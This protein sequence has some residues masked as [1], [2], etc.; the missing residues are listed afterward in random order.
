MRC[1]T[2]LVTITQFCTAQN[3][4]DDTISQT[5]FAEI[6]SIWESEDGRYLNTYFNLHV[7]KAKKEQ[8]TLELA[9]AYRYIAWSLPMKEGIKSVDSAISIISGMKRLDKVDLDE[10][11]TLAYYTK[12]AQFYENY[13]DEQ[14]TEAFI[15]S[16]HLAKKSNHKDLMIIV[17]SELANVKAEFGQESEAIS[18]Q[19]KTLA[20]LEKNKTK[21][22]DYQSLHLDNLHTMVRCYTY[23]KK[24]DSARL[25]LKEAI[26]IATENKD[27]DELQDLREISAEVDYYDNDILRAKDTL[28]K[29]IKNTNGTSKANKLFYLGQ[30][31]GRLGYLDL[32]K[33]YFQSFDSIMGTI[34]Y[35]LLDNANEVY[36]FLLKDA[37][38][39]NSHAEKRYFNRLVYYDSLLARTQERLRE[40]TLKKFDL[41]LQQEEESLMNNIISS[42]S[43][44]I[45]VFYFICGALIVGLLGYY[46][47]YRNTKKR[48]ELALKQP[49][50]LETGNFSKSFKEPTIDID[51]GILQEILKNLD[52]WEKEK[53]FLDNTVNQQSLAKTLNTNSSYLSQ[54]INVNK[55]HNFSSYL[56]DLRITYAINNLKSS[57]NVVKGKSMIQIAELYGFS[58]LAVF[59]KAFKA[60]VGVT[61]GVFLKQLEKESFAQLD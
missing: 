59:N 38:D 9:R 25:Y 39:N 45:Q 35:P 34:N 17:L 13:Y 28:S 6:R 20:F 48:L 49:V 55:G 43:K 10:F 1:F 42:K 36:R 44:R 24:V 19:K 31:E 4:T 51:A 15:K 14:A 26:K 7:A 50:E 58:S 11:M 21:V 3:V 61:P 37:I 40:I 18:L 12:G 23:A 52:H 41:P 56:K 22:A 60:K 53:G 5:T 57:P 8:D 29:Y 27:T 47:K 30:I 32:K 46:L 54:V 16:F 33:E 2:L